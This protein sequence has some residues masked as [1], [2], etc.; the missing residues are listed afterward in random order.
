MAED[1]GCLLSNDRDSD[2]EREAGPRA[3]G[4]EG[5][6]GEAL[7]KGEAGAIEL[8]G[9]FHI[10][11][12]KLGALRQTLLFFAAHLLDALLRR[13]LLF[14]RESASF[15]DSVAHDT[16]DLKVGLVRG[17]RALDVIVAQLFG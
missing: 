1:V 3:I 6:K 11:Q 17:G 14:G 10:E 8:L 2:A 9:I 4:R 13:G 16:P 15:D 12:R 5:G 7:G